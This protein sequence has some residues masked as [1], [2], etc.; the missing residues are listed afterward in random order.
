MRRPYPVFPS[1][2]SF[3]Q[4]ES[5]PNH[6]RVV[7]LLLFHT[8]PNLQARLEYSSNIQHGHRATEQPYGVSL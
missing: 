1:F 6:Y 3:K 7:D 5:L 2:N 4:I 8:L